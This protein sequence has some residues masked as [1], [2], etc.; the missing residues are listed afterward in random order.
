MPH[1]VHRLTAHSLSLWLSLCHSL[2]PRHCLQLHLSQDSLYCSSYSAAAYLSSIGFDRSKKVRWLLRASGRLLL[3]AAQKGTHPRR[4]APRLQVYVVGEQGIKDELAAV[5]ISAS[6]G[7]ADNDKRCSFSN[8]MQHDAAV[9]AGRLRRQ[10]RLGSRRLRPHDRATAATRSCL[11]DD[12]EQSLS[13][14]QARLDVPHAL[15]GEMV[16]ALLCVRALP[17]PQVGAVVCGVDPGLNY[18]KIKV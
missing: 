10:Q 15:T 11:R 17:G 13:R 7:P 5:G 2:A 12:R 8:E 3:H 16:A 6:G 1:S 9:R 18:F 14:R 4:A